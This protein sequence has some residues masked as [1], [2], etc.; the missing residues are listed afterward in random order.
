[1]V[2]ELI[3]NATDDPRVTQLRAICNRLG[4]GYGRAASVIG[5]GPDCIRRSFETG[6]LPGRTSSQRRIQKF[7][8]LNAQTQTLADLKVVP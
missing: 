2:H 4:L 8:E 7:C 6:K 1:M 3:T 5:T